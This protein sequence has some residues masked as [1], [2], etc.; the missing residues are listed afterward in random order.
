MA[1]AIPLGKVSEIKGDGENREGKRTENGQDLGKKWFKTTDEG[2][3]FKEA[4]SQSDK[5]MTEEEDNEVKEEEDNKEDDVL[6]DPFGS[7]VS[8][9]SIETEGMKEETNFVKSLLK[10]L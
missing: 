6:E 8:R 4:L 1:S 3:N 2:R 7:A 5:G 10:R 9:T